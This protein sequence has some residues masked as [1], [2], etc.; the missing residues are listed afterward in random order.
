MTVQYN[1]H[2]T[3]EDCAV[4]WDFGNLD[5]H[6][7][8]PTKSVFNKYCLPNNDGPKPEGL[9]FELNNIVGDLAIADIQEYWL[10]VVAAKIAYI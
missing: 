1:G 2:V 9:D 6:Y 7:G 10:D 3:S 8:Y 5:A 4:Q